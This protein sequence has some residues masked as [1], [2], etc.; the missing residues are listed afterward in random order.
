M[1]DWNPSFKT[2][3]SYTPDM[4]L[5]GDHPVRTMGITLA[6]GQSLKRGALLGRVTATGK[7]LLSMTATGDGSQVPSAI[8]GEDT[9]AMTADVVTFAYVAGDFNTH[10]MTFGADHTPASV[11]DDLHLRSIYLY[12]PING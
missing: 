1:N 8:L 6:G 2:E 5:A 12:T 11:C 9:D 4:L 10:Q 3:G 7:Y